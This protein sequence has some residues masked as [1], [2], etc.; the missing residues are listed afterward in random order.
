ML[1]QATTVQQQT[2]VIHVNTMADF[3]DVKNEPPKLCCYIKT[4]HMIIMNGFFYL[5]HKQYLSHV[6]FLSFT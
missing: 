5:I 4:K 3:T 6:L 2:A 1:Q